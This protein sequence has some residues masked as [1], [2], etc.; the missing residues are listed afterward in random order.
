MNIVEIRC[1]ICNKQID[2]IESNNTLKTVISD[3]INCD[4]CLDSAAKVNYLKGQNDTLKK[5][6][7]KTDASCSGNCGTHGNGCNCYPTKH[8]KH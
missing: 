4:Q 5:Q 6:I 7:F 8:K 1:G 2:Y 3:N